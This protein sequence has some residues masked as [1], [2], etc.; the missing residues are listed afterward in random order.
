MDDGEPGSWSEEGRAAPEFHRRDGTRQRRRDKKIGPEV[1]IIGTFAGF[2]VGCCGVPY[3][4]AA[5]G[6]LGYVP[7]IAVSV[8]VAGCGTWRL[9]AVFLDTPVRSEDQFIGPLR[10]S[11]KV[12]CWASEETP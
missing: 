1:M 11:I 3:L 10:P 6:H 5:V 2:I 9:I 7:L 12:M 8:C 4:F